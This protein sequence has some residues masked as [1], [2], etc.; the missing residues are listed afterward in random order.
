MREIAAQTCPELKQDTFPVSRPHQP[1]ASVLER[2]MGRLHGEIDIG[3]RT[4]RES[5][6]WA[7]RRRIEHFQQCITR[8]GTMFALDEGA[9]DSLYGSNDFRRYPYQRTGRNRLVHRDL[10]RCAIF[11]PGRSCF[12]SLQDCERS[13][14]MN[15]WPR[16][17]HFAN[18]HL[19]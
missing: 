11:K 3:R 13:D 18:R 17:R 12:E 5:G 4:F 14:A 19:D 2:A 7:A 8:A 15:E 9:H 6:D 10:L 16:A 1:P